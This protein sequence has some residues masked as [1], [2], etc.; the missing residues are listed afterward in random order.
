MFGIGNH[1]HTNGNGHVDLSRVRIL[2]LAGGDEAS[3]R[4]LTELVRARGLH[5]K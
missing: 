2:E 1:D 4:D 3:M 5:G